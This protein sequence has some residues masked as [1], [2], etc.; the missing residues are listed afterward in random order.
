MKS[1]NEN[2]N[3]FN[4]VGFI[5]R[6]DGFIAYVIGLPSVKAQELVIFE[7]NSIGEVIS[8]N[9]ENVQVMVFSK[10]TLR[11][12]MRA[13]RT[14]LFLTIP[15][16]ETLLGS[17]IDP[18]GVPLDPDSYIRDPSALVPM[19]NEAW[20]ISRRKRIS[21][22][23]E[24]G[25]SLVDLAIPLGRGQRELIIGDRQ[26]GKTS[27]VL[28]TLLLQARM[29]TICI[30]AG[31]G[32]KK[33]DIKRVEEFFIE[34]GIQNNTVIVATAS[35]DPAS[36]IYLTPYAAM[37]VAEY[38]RD[39]GKHVFLIL[40]DL[41]T[42]GKFYR[43]IS[44]LSG[45]LPGRNSYPADVFFAHSQLL[46][47]AG[48]FI[49]A[50][51]DSSITCFVVADTQQ[52]D[53]SGYMQTNIMSMT[54]GH[55]FFDLDYFLSGRRPAINPFLSVTRVGKQ[56]QV[57][58]RRDISRE[59]HTFLTYAERLMSYAH[60]GEEATISVRAVLDMQARI[61]EFFVQP[62][63]ISMPAAFQVYIF[64]LIW[65]NK[66]KDIPID[67]MKKQILEILKIYVSDQRF[68]NTIELVVSQ[69]TTLNNL[70]NR[71]IKSGMEKSQE[72]ARG[73]MHK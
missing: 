58:V 39:Q 45:R 13:S 34:N 20:G 14:N 40:D 49:T 28:Q 18:F 47:R 35:H 60:F 1:F 4:E 5:Y 53:L 50:N 16:G 31:I 22:P 12:R 15:V 63:N 2:L 67:V 66:W 29:G 55:I 19:R 57:P 6:M 73:G 23:F 11:I 42:H 56:V 54:D 64:A 41:V 59:L 52:G 26:T 27:F 62:S 9:G 68:R 36:L 33:T 37:G 8:F 44:L 24:T 38:F 72:L 7:D 3:E 65:Q 25:V 43:E 70:L 32:K 30:Y 69:S 48:N 51:G 46:E 21:T 17:C 10:A 71:I 61:A